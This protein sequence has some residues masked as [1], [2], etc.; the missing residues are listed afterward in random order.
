[1]T[2]KALDRVLKGESTRMDEYGDKVQ[3]IGETNYDVADQLSNM[4]MEAIHPRAAKSLRQA[5]IPLRVKNTFDINDEG[6]VIEAG[7]GEK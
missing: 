4:G 6:T 5:G 3:V 2:L 7:F 1:M